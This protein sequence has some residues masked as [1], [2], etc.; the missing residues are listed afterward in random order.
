MSG[1]ET[2]ILSSGR[3]QRRLTSADIRRR[4]DLLVAGERKAKA[5][6]DYL[7]WVMQRESDRASNVLERGR[8]ESGAEACRILAS[9]ITAGRMEDERWQF[10][11]GV[12]A[13]PVPEEPRKP[14][15]RP[16][17]PFSSDYQEWRREVVDGAL[18]EV[19]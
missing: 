11:S 8:L 17:K 19:S 7:G 14:K 5:V 15:H 3:T 10:L 12:T 2:T 6:F 1:T 16:F 9:R 18:D 13:P 4:G